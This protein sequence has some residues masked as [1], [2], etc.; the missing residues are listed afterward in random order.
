MLP[1]HAQTSI[2]VVGSYFIEELVGARTNTE[3]LQ[4]QNNMFAEVINYF[5]A[6]AGAQELPVRSST[7]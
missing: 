5:I 2:V 4:E 3:L 6:N 7:A 1:A